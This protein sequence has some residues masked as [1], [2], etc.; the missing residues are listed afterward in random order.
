MI[1]LLVVPVDKVAGEGAGIFD[2]AKA[3]QVLR[4]VLIVLSWLFD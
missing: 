2:G 3:L 1:V 4:P